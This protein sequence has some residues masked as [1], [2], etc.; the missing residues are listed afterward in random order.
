[1]FKKEPVATP[2]HLGV[3]CIVYDVRYSCSKGRR[4][5]AQCYT[6]AMLFRRLLLV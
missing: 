3:I 1:M 5:L 6:N 4:G 2:L